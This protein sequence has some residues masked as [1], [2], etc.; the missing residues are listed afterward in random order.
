LV[1]TVAALHPKTLIGHCERQ[2][3]RLLGPAIANL[4]H[5]TLA[6]QALCQARPR[7]RATNSATA[8]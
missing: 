7:F 2:P 8:K 4:L 6:A 1:E 5:P 3:M